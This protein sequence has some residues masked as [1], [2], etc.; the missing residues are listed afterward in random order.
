MTY[1]SISDDLWTEWHWQIHE[2]TQ[3]QPRRSGDCQC[4]RQAATVQKQSENLQERQLSGDYE[5][6]SGSPAKIHRY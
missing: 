5:S 2:P 1:F 3:F 4:V 6:D